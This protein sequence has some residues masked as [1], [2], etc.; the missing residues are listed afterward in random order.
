MFKL[1]SIAV[2]LFVLAAGA[3]LDVVAAENSSGGN[4]KEKETGS[5]HSASQVKNGQSDFKGNVKTS[6]HIYYPG[7]PLSISVQFARGSELLASGKASAFVV[8][9]SFDGTATSMPVPKDIGVAS[10]QFYKL[11]SVDTKTLKEGQYQLGL[12]VTVAGG[13]PLKLT[14][15]YSGFRGLLDMQAILVSSTAVAGDKNH[16]GELDND[17]NK[18]GLDEEAD[19][20]ESG[21]K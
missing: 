18:D 21:K 17:R 3:G 1:K 15:W 19:E 12:V 5:V 20:P 2:P 8:I 11:D 13:D 16:D 9:Y 6:Q 10:R 7:D 4:E 14:S